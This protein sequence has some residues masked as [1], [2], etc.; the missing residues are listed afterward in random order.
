[1]CWQMIELN[2]C[3]SKKIKTILLS[4]QKKKKKLEMC[5]LEHVWPAIQHS[6]KWGATTIKQQYNMGNQFKDLNKQKKN[7]VSRRIV[8]T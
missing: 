4:R 7:Y 6:F 5:P 1:M 2:W 8:I 3:N